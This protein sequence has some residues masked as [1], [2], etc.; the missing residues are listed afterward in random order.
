MLLSI[1]LGLVSISPPKN[2][3]SEQFFAWLLL[4]LFVGYVSGQ[5]LDSFLERGNARAGDQ[6]VAAIEKFRVARSRYPEKLSDLV[7]DFIEVIPFVKEGFENI[8]FGYSV[9]NDSFTLGYRRPAMMYY[10]YD[11]RK[12]KWRLR[13]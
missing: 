12:K 2:V 8:P 11:S 13:D 9:W 6:L 7:P 3:A 5:A 1:L 10:Q 4:L